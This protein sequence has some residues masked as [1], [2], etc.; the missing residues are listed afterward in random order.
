VL[1]LSSTVNYHY[2]DKRP[3]HDLDLEFDF[4]MS[5]EI[6]TELIFCIVMIDHGALFFDPNVIHNVLLI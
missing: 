2:N 6:L 1:L 3:T 4:S 5:C